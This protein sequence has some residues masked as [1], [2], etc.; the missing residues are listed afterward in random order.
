MSFLITGATG[1]IG[2]FVTR[3]LLD[4]GARVAVLTRRPHR[5]RELLGP[6]VTIH[7]WHSNSEPPPRAAVE[8]AR[9]VVHLMGEPIHGRLTGDKA[10]RI[11]ASRV[12][13]TQALVQAFHGRAV[14]WIVASSAAVYPARWGER[15]DE[16]FPLDPP[17]SL[18]QGAFQQ[19]EQ[20]AWTATGD[21]SQVTLV[22][23]GAIIDEQALPR[24]FG[25]LSR[26]VGFRIGN[27]RQHVP[28]IG[29][30]D[31][32]RLVLWLLSTP[33]AVGPVNGV[34]PVPLKAG[35][36]LAALEGAQGRL[37]RL[38]LPDRLA[39]RLLGASAENLIRN[40]NVR[41]ERA[42]AAGFVFREPDPVALVHRLVTAGAPPAALAVPAKA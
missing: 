27:G 24:P 16:D 1:R 21:G 19:L 14:R 23:F 7:E 35:E 34:T 30:S 17:Q 11:T 2:R 20:A 42:L 40:N 10:S 41:P 36:L 15:Y 22:R 9:I 18:L 26:H 12:R 25:G 4:V 13:P 28:V 5:A 37:L 8:D 3:Q 33:S 39:Y 32:Q 6:A 29:L 38:P 31:A